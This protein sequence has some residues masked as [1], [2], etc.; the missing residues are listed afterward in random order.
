MTKKGIT[1]VYVD[2]ALLEKAKRN[3]LNLSQ[4]VENKLKEYIDVVES[5]QV[6]TKEHMERS[7]DFEV[8]KFLEETKDDYMKFI[9]GRLRAINI[10]LGTHMTRNEFVARIIEIKDKVEKD[11]KVGEDKV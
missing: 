11:G 10:R 4:F 2:S 7:K 5:S 3:S 8:L 1:T 9:D 6:V